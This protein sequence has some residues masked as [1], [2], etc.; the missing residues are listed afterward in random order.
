MRV[1]ENK[2]IFELRLRHAGK[3]L[4]RDRVGVV[5]GSWGYPVRGDGAVPLDPLTHWS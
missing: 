1:I 5:D 3:K 2:I 4:G